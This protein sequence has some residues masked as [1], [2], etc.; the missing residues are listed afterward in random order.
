MGERKGNT[1]SPEP[2]I[3]RMA[4]A[5]ALVGILGTFVIVL[6]IG[7]YRPWWSEF[8]ARNVVG[9]LGIVG[10]ALGFVTLWRVSKRIAAIALLVLLSSFF[11]LLCSFFPH[12][13]FA[14][15]TAGCQFLQL[16]SFLLS[17]GFLLSLLAMPTTHAWKSRS[18]E[19]F[20]GGTF[21]AVG[22]VLSAVLAGCWLAETCGQVSTAMRMGCVVNVKQMGIVMLIYASDNGGRYPE[23]A[24]WCDLL[25][26]RGKMET[27]HFL[28]PRVKWEWRRRV[29]PWPVP[30]NERCYYAM[31]PNC[32]PN[33]PSDTVL[34]FETKGGWNKFG[35]PELLTL[36]NHRGDGC[37]ILFNDRRAEFVIRKRISDLKWGVEEK[38]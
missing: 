25:L 17:I 12:L 9:L 8:A 31:N 36:E 15:S 28:C 10:L 18:R 24:R 5:S 14:K 27:E 1:Q 3:S 26:Q 16:C 37:S 35:G 38:D 32:D 34:L 6:R 30:K 13:L 4:I 33:A 2:K 7:F 23:P 21:A 29:F 20:K 11:L 19:K 22:M